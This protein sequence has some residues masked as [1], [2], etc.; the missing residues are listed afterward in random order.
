MF[1]I[2]APLRDEICA[3][4]LLNTH[5]P[6]KA[7]LSD[8]VKSLWLQPEREYHYFAQ[9]LV[10]KYVKQFSKPDIHLLEF[11]ALNNS[12]WDTI[13]YIATKLMAA[14]F[15]LYP[16]QINPITRAWMDSG[17]IWLQRSCLLF[18][19]KYKLALDTNLLSQYIA[20][21]KNSKEFFIKKAIGWVLREYSKTNSLWVINFVKNNQ[22]APLSQ[23]EAMKFIAASIEKY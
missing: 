2:H 23:R 7:E 9:I 1:G 19:L 6:T 10:S 20:E 22:L 18:Q 12:W 16:E 17:N 3:T 5:R 15:K 13:D 11:M 21:L 14:Y 4:F 8:I